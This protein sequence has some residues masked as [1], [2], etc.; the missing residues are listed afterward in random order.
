MASFV[1]NFAM[2]KLKWKFYLI[3]ASWNVIFL[4]IVY[5]FYP[6]TKG[7]SLEEIAVFFDG[8]QFID[9]ALAVGHSSNEEVFT[10]KGDA[11]VTTLAKA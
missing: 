9:G 4:L 2:A 1:M 10:A 11:N 3:N 8:S 5:F 6:E 7:V